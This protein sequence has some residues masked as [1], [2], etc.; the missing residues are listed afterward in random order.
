MKITWPENFEPPQPLKIYDSQDVTIVIFSPAIHPNKLNLKQ[1]KN[2]GIIPS[3]WRIKKSQKSPKIASTYA[4]YS[5]ME[6]LNIRIFQGKIMFSTK[7]IHE[8]IDLSEITKLFIAKYG[9]QS[10]QKVQIIFRRVITLPANDHHTGEIFIRDRLLNDRD[11]E[12]MGQKPLNR[13]VNL[14]LRLFPCSFDD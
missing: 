13:R 7:I 14:F 11:W 5:F 6:G 10:Y 3:H 8:H 2:K 1:L 4:Q 12:F 9:T